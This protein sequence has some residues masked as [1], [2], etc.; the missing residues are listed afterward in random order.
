MAFQNYILAS[1]TITISFMPILKINLHGESWMLKKFDCPK[2]DLIECYKVANKM[3]L[4]LT[5]ALLD[6]FFYYN[7]KKQAIPSLEHLPGIKMTGLLNTTKNQIEILLNGKKIR[8]L[9]INDL[10]DP[11]I[12]FPLYYIIRLLEI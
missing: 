9:I 8:K 2:D 1:L 5:E 4:S 12:L 7:L 11:F 6:P 10:I 3:N